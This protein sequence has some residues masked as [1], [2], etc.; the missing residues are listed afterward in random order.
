MHNEFI[1]LQP[2]FWACDQGKDLQKCRPRVN[3]GITF[4]V[5]GNA[6]ECEGINPHT[7]K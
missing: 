2:L 4:H 5:P 1:V 6:K 3:L 7:P